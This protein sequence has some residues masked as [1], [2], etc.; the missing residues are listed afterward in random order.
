MQATRQ[1][2]QPPR[3]EL[4]QNDLGVRPGGGHKMVEHAC[5]TVEADSSGRCCTRHS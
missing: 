4:A 2:W 5:C 1:H 3:R